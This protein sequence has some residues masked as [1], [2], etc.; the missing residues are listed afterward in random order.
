MPGE[1]S[2]RLT[3][4]Q[5][6]DVFTELD[7]DGNGHISPLDM[8]LIMQQAGL[9]CSDVDIDEMLRMGDPDGDGQVSLADFYSVL[10][11]IRSKATA[12]EASKSAAADRRRRK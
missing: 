3:D 1:G 8:R 4:T 12:I 2:L 5:A 11:D 10:A 6:H 9:V 7:V